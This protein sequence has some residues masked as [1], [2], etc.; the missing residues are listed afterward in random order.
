MRNELGRQIN[1]LQDRNVETISE[2]QK[3]NAKEKTQFIEGA[4]RELYNSREEM[5][6]ANNF[7]RQK[8]VDSYNKK[9]DSL[10]L[11][12]RKTVEM[13]ETQ[14]ENMKKKTGEE[15]NQR[16]AMDTQRR[17]LDIRNFKRAMESKIRESDLAIT[18]V[19]REF[20]KKLAE[21]KHHSE[22]HLQ[23]IVERYE[24]EIKRVSTDQ[25]RMLDRKLRESREHYLR[26]AENSEI[27]KEQIRSM[28]EQKLQAQQQI[29]EANREKMRAQLAKAGPFG[30]D[31]QA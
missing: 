25:A 23:K 17:E 26:L 7:Q 10:E 19:R 18:N 6:D 1:M 21:N 16:S 29:N 30:S 28:Y 12:K 20:D 2:I 4:K 11:E 14:I 24:D 9:I 22:M 13:Y 27:E 5:R 31:N 3:E 8:I 15:L